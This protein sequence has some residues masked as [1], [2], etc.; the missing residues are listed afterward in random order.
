MISA[1][2][3]SGAAAG[4]RADAEAAA[5]TLVV[6]W[7]DTDH[8]TNGTLRTTSATR[9]AAASRIT[10][11]PPPFGGIGIAAATSPSSG[12]RRR[13]FVDDSLGVRAAIALELSFDP[14]D[15][16]AISLRALAT[17]AELCQSFDR[18]LVFL[19]L[20][21]RNHRFDLGR[22]SIERRSTSRLRRRGSAG[23]RDKSCGTR[24]GCCS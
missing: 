17:I 4:A 2:P 16:I 9:T 3:V 22:A 19:Q 11:A 6:R 10:T 13:V 15:S 7:T 21:A 14:V 8:T 12:V 5:S 20:E 18:R 24:E 1:V 23:E